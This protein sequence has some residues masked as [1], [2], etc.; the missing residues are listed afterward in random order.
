MIILNIELV[1]YLLLAYIQ[2]KFRD[3]YVIVLQVF[4]I[5]FIVGLVF[6]GVLIILVKY[7]MKTQQFQK[8]KIQLYG[9]FLLTISILSSLILRIEYVRPDIVL[10]GI[11]GYGIVL[12]VI[13]IMINRM[14]IAEKMERINKQNQM[15]ENRVFI[16]AICCWFRT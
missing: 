13:V 14:K 11:I 4:L 10:K 3:S 2:K 8:T 15:N 12:I 5:I 6:I 1:F 9:I 16:H 7:G